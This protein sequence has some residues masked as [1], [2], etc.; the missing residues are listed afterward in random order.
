ML[1]IIVLSVVALL[2]YVTK[3]LSLALL[4]FI[5]LSVIMMSGVEL[6]VAVGILIVIMLSA[7]MI[8]ISW[9][10]L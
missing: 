9:L 3:K 4:T 1:S 7:I 10:S 6:G 5:I 8:S 2:C